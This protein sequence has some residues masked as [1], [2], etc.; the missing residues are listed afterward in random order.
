ML[1]NSVAMSQASHEALHGHLLR[2]DGQEDIC[3]ATYA[4]SSGSRR[5]TRI[6]N[7]VHLPIDGDRLVHGNATINGGY[8][9]RVAALAAKQGLGIAII[10]SHPDGR[11]WQRL[12][13]P[14]FDAECSYAALAEQVTG[15]PLV[16]LT[17]AGDGTWSGRA[18]T[19]GKPEWAGCVRR[20][21]TRL[22]LSWNDELV[23][24]N[25]LEASQDRTISAWG[26]DLQRDIGRMRVLVV[27]AGSVG[28]DVVQRLAATGV[29]E[30]GIMD[31]D[32]VD[33]VNRDRMIGATRRDARLHRRKV[34]VAARL[35]RLASTAQ[36]FSVTRHYTSVC[37]PEG[38]A[39]ALDYDL[40]FS[41]VDRPWPRAVLNTIAY[42][43][44]VPVI[45]GG[46]SIDTFPS[47]RMRSATRRTQVVAPG[48]P[49]LACSGQISLSEVTLEM[50]GD[51]DDPAYIRR[52]GR[53]PVSG[54]PNVAALCAGVSSS[55]LDL[56]V[57]LLAHP[58]GVGAPRPLRFALAL[59]HLQHLAEESQ[60]YCEAEYRVGVGDARTNLCRPLGPWSVRDERSWLSR[61]SGDG[62][63][64]LILRVMGR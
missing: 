63:D 20:V 1:A 17:L 56:F 52:A 29:A 18:W 57:S 10:H 4:V 6:L 39:A 11:G 19:G 25:R 32:R 41:C 23:P 51:L 8:V 42:S 24:P 3:I 64:A 48:I 47:G 59:H 5:V 44:L 37:S 43:D 28:L 33:E 55:Q 54:R 40:I 12:S 9:L 58:A 36:E 38:L 49:C 46:L 35:A 27:G 26:E 50:N 61:M 45:D 2:R 60:P 62:I 13:G 14:D 34:D 30:V 22:T 53:Q 7:E 16:G 15:L 31:F 21:G